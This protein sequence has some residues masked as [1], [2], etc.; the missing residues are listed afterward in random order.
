MRLLLSWCG[1][2]PTS[3]A[4]DKLVVDPAYSGRSTSSWPRLIAINAGS[5]GY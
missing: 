2:V 4:P 1:V 5:D 3:L